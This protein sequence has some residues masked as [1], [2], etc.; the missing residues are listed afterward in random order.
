[1][2][3]AES[4]PSSDALGVWGRQDGKEKE[5][6][7][8]LSF[9]V[10]KKKKDSRVQDAH[11]SAVHCHSHT[12]AL[13]WLR[14]LHVV[15]FVPADLTHGVG[16]FA[17]SQLC[18]PTLLFPSVPGSLTPDPPQRLGSC[19]EPTTVRGCGGLS[20]KWAGAVAPEKT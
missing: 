1:M 13:G 11:N 9:L 18:L 20:G 19:E 4:R 12:S 17:S 2:V 5:Q 7:M 10:G 14:A 6:K 8:F 16:G 3:G 15:I